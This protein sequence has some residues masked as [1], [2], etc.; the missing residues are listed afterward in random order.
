[1]TSDEPSGSTPLITPGTPSNFHAMSN[2]NQDIKKDYPQST[3]SHGEPR[4]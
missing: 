4:R 3:R 2:M 1:M